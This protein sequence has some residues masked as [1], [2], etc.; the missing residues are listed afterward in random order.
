MSITYGHR[1][2][3]RQPE[4]GF[5]GDGISP[6]STTRAP[7]RCDGGL[8]TGIAESSASVYGCVGASYSAAAGPSSTIWPRYIT[9]I[10]SLT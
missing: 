10:R 9:A 7:A 4:G 8:G 3:N 6:R 5:A 1:V 2:R